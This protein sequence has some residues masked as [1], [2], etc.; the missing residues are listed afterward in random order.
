MQ[1]EVVDCDLEFQAAAGETKRGVTELRG[2]EMTLCVV[3][4]SSAFTGNAH[5]VSVQFAVGVF[6]V[7][8]GNSIRAGCKPVK[9]QT[10][11]RPEAADWVRTR[12]LLASFGKPSADE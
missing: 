10:P 11:R 7:E 12:T 8:Q 5:K 9:S 4:G 3:G 6:V 2:S 1:L